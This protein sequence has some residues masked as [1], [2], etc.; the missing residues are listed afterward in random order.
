MNVRPVKDFT[1][2]GHTTGSRAEDVSRA[3]GKGTEVGVG[4]EDCGEFAVAIGVED[5]VG[6]VM[7]STHEKNIS[8]CKG[9]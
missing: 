6:A 5:G 9:T 1:K 2:I 3:D 4:S 8:Q 7:G